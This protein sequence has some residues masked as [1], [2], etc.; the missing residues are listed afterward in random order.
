VT[1]AA[2]VL[3]GHLDAREDSLDGLAKRL[4]HDL[5]ARFTR[6][7][8]LIY[9]VIMANLRICSTEAGATMDEEDCVALWLPGD[10]VN[11]MI[12]HARRERPRECCGLLVGTGGVVESAVPLINESPSPCDSYL[13]G[14]GLLGPFQ[15]MRARGQELLAIYHSHPASPALPSQRDLAEN[16]YGSVVHVII[17]LALVDPVVRAYRL[18][19]STF[20]EVAW[21]RTHPEG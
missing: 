10:I 15:A 5:S 13:V 8:W 2:G 19:A 4:V 11:A 7:G 20:E 14:V 9:L 6:R 17:S 21:R 1:F 3:A 18:A 12:D 16:Y